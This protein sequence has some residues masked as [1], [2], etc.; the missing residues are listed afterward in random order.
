MPAF[1]VIDSIVRQAFKQH[2]EKDVFGPRFANNLVKT[3]ENAMNC[4][5]E[6]RVSNFFVI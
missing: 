1:Y 6:D 2:K 5:N 3:L 4:P